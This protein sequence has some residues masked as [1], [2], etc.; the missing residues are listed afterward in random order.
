MASKSGSSNLA[1][2]VPIYVMLQCGGIVRDAVCIPIQIGY[3]PL[4]KKFPM[5]FTLTDQMYSDYL[6]SF[7]ENMSDILEAG[8]NVDIDVGPCP[9]GEFRYPSYPEPQGCFPR[10]WRILVL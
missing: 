1:N 9:E 3:L 2:Y 10:H 5:F 4:E 6:K 7:R 8:A